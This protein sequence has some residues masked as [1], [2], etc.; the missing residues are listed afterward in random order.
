MLREI[1]E[2]L[3]AKEKTLREIYVDDRCKVRN[4]L[5]NIFGETT[6]IKLHLFHAIQR[7]T[8]NTSKRHSLFSDFVSSFKLVFRDPTDLGDARLMVTPDPL[9]LENNLNA[10][11]ERWKSAQLHDGKKNFKLR[12]LGRNNH[13]AKGCLWDQAW[14]SH[15]QGRIAS[16]KKLIVL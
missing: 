3:Q 7:V 12:C 16:Q 4:K 13:I 14:K 8:R 9:T 15:E 11:V 6:I 5:Q 10:F 1:K 2:R